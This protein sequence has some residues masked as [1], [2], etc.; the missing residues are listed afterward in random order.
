MALLPIAI[1]ANREV[2]LIIPTTPP[3]TVITTLTVIPTLPEIREI[4]I[5]A[6]QV[7]M[8]HLDLEALVVAAAAEVELAEV[9]VDN[10]IN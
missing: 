5:Q 6:D 2:T 9:A 1:P 8:V 4:T 3:E 7:E 10:F